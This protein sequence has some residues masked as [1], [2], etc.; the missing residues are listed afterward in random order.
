MD[1]SGVQAVSQSIQMNNDV[2]TM[3]HTETTDLIEKAL[4]VM[5]ESQAS[6]AKGKG[7]LINILG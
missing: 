3:M 2:L 1:I 6:S 4:M 5:E 7:E